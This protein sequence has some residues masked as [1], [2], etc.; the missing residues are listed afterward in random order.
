MY[1][2]FYI[3]ANY[4]LSKSILQFTLIT[5]TLAVSTL[6]TYFTHLFYISIVNSFAIKGKNDLE[7]YWFILRSRFCLG[8]IITKS[9]SDQGRHN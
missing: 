4:E 7:L 8:G 1:G 3:I 2:L 5:G 6:F 9:M